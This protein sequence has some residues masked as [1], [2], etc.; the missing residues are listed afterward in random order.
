VGRAPSE[1]NLLVFYVPEESK[2][3]AR[4]EAM[5]KAGFLGVRSY[6]PFWD[7]LGRTFEDADGYRV[8]IQRDHWPL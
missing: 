2:W 5:E 7:G 4:C 1:D 3:R 8:V 6:N